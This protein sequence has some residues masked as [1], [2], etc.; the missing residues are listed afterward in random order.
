M[1]D[2]QNAQHM[3]VLLMQE[4]LRETLTLGSFAVTRM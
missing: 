2:L 4:S 1:L 3:L